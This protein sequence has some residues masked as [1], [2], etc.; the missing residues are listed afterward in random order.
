[1]EKIL[2][3]MSFKGK[4]G[5]YIT[6]EARQKMARIY[7]EVTKD[8]HSCTGCSTDWIKRLSHWYFESKNRYDKS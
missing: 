4:G 3:R 6:F 5:L 1:F 7:T 2:T 8:T